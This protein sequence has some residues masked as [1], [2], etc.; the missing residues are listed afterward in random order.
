MTNLKVIYR[1]TK[2]P[3]TEVIPCDWNDDFEI[4]AKRKFQTNTSTT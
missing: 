1:W 4:H 2:F 3:L